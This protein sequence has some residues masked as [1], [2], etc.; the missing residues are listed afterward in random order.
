MVELNRNVE[1]EPYIV[2][3]NPD[4]KKPYVVEVTQG[5][6]AKAIAF[7]AQDRGMHPVTPD[8]LVIHRGINARDIVLAVNYCMGEKI[9]VNARVVWE[10]LKHIPHDYK[11]LGNILNACT[12]GIQRV[13]EKN[14]NVYQTKI[15]E[16]GEYRWLRKWVE[17]MFDTAVNKALNPY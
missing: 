4:N 12:L 5:N 11:D 10:L 2:E 16:I 8:K 9:S 14:G 13:A 17:P 7:L 1:P 15:P 3:L 6:I